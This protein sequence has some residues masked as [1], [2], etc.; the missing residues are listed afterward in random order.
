MKSNILVL[1][2]L[3]TNFVP[4]HSKKLKPCKSLDLKTD[5]VNIQKFSTVKYLGVT[6][7]LNLTWENHVNELCLR[8]RN[9]KLWAYFAN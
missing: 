4:F 6:V 7:D 2:I 8:L 9:Q 1:S 3:K 5:G